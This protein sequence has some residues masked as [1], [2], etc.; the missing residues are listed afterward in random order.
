MN[1]WAQSI[2][3]PV[4]ARAV[5]GLSICSGLFFLWQ[6]RNLPA[7]GELQDDGIYAS[8]ALS[9]DQGKGYRIPILP[10][11]PVQ[12]KYPPLY[13]AVLAKLCDLATNFPLNL[14]PALLLGAISYSA[15]LVLL[16]GLLR[17]W[18]L[19]T[20]RSLLITA[21]AA[22]N[23]ILIKLSTSIMAE[24]HFMVLLLATISL[25]RW[26]VNRS[27][28]WM[29][30]AGL[31]AS[32]GYLTRTAAIALLITI[33]L[34]LLWQSRPRHA[35]VFVFSVAPA[36]VAWQ[37]WVFAHPAVAKDWISL[38][39]NDYS[40][41]EKA[42]VS[43][44]NL[45]Q[46]VSVNLQA[47]LAAMSELLLLN[48]FDSFFG[49]Q[50]SR[51]LLLAVIL[52]A[53]RLSC[54]SGQWYFLSFSALYCALLLIWHYPSNQRLV[55]PLLPIL[56]AG[57]FDGISHLANL[58]QSSWQSPKAS[59]RVAAACF[60]FLLSVFGLSLVAFLLIAR[61]AILPQMYQASLQ[62]TK[63]LEPVFAQVRS[64]TPPNATILSDQDTMLHLKTGRF[65]YRIIVPPNVLYTRPTA[66]FKAGFERLPDGAGQP[67]QFA[68]ITQADWSYALPEEDRA[69]IRRRIATRPD[70]TVLYQDA[71]AI[72]YRRDLSSPAPTPTPKA[73]APNQ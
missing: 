25:T 43:W 73:K 9:L 47:L 42:S 69:E 56:L 1:S 20:P 54:R 22:I 5:F 57:L 59:K 40:G 67:W 52:G 4:L 70:L 61:F 37:S 26:S 30:A 36:V 21:L 15:F 38:F 72:L 28:N 62:Q 16:L 7:F 3:L 50:F 53:V 71:F 46:V 2:A 31:C 17:S 49:S 23:P 35:T 12:T 14:Q 44:H 29:I 11:S 66:E 33:P 24:I 18:G 64:L 51:L 13:P 6:Q 32:L 68:L 58:L 41:L 19:G 34:V 63:L 27:P 48:I 8:L 55:L 60:A 45:A 39:Y 10:G 65:S